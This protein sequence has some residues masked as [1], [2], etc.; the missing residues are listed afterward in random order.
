MI[1]PLVRKYL[2]TVLLL[3][4]LLFATG[5]ATYRLT[6]SPMTG[7]DEG[8]LVQMAKNFSERGA[9][10]LQIQPDVFASG[11]Y[12]ST[13]YPI[14]APVGVAMRLFGPTLL[15]ARGTMVIFL[16]A[17][18]F[19]FHLASRRVFGKRNALMATAL[20]ATHASFYVYG[21]PVMGEIPG[22]MYVALFLIGLERLSRQPK[23]YWLTLVLTAAALGLAAVTKPIFL[24]ALP[25]AAI[26]LLI[27]RK[28][29]PVSFATVGAVAAI[30]IACFLAWFA[31]QFFA[32]DDAAKILLFYRNP[33]LTQDVGSL[34][35][36]NIKRFFTEATP[37]YMVGLLIIWVVSYVA[38]I[39]DARRSAQALTSVISAVETF[40]LAFVL[41]IL[42]AYVRTPGFYRYFFLANVFILLPLPFAIQDLVTRVL[43]RVPSLKTGMTSRY[44]AV[45]IWGILLMVQGYRL[46]FGSYITTTYASTQTA[47]LEQYFGHDFE[48]ERRVYLYD[49]PE[50]MP[51]LPTK[52]YS[53]WM[54]LSGGG[55]FQMGIPLHEALSAKPDAIIVH[56]HRYNEEL[57]HF[58]G[59]HQ[60]A[61]VVRYVVL[62][63]DTV[64][65]TSR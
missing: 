11:A 63:P 64:T 10:V 25:A 7:Y 50:I 42:A 32:T 65:S 14:L 20:M 16:L 48:P 1:H 46:F 57:D 59:Y 49:V 47:E 13:A 51:F 3:L 4:V 61:F 28:K 29:L 2:P 56:E 21:K 5:M 9:F 38:R 60:A 27:Y 54:E 24:L 39:R 53:Q 8:I 58:P 33:Y 45:F 22:L 35:I 26:T 41:L 37:L 6:E 55:G 30:I 18:L 23:R 17:F 44:A 31:T 40:C 15:T 36:A 62:E 43:R 19:F 34:V 52:N 12:M